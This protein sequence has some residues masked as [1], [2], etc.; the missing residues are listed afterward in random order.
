M[1]L[2]TYSTSTVPLE[3]Y[4]GQ[5]DAMFDDI[6]SL[7][8]GST[9]PFAAPMCVAILSNNPADAVIALTLEALGIARLSWHEDLRAT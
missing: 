6:R 2:D 8:I 4:K 1:L 5:V 7:L 3:I 9:A